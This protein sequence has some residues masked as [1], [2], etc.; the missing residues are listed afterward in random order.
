[1]EALLLTAGFVD[2]HFL[3]HPVHPDRGIFHARK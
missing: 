2:V 3:R 1:V